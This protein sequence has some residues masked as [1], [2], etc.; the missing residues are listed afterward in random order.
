MILA[1][2]DRGGIKDEDALPLA[3]GFCENLNDDIPWLRLRPEARSTRPPNL[4]NV[5]ISPFQ[6]GTRLRFTNS[7]VRFLRFYDSLTQRFGGNQPYP[8]FADTDPGILS[9]GRLDGSHNG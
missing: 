7:T 9:P 2:Y 8:G 5:V 3:P 6:L 4:L 1:V